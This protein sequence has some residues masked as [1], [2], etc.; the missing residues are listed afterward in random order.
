SEKALDLA[1]QALKRAQKELDL[2][3]MSPLDI[4]Q[5]QQVYATAEIGVSQA[6]FTLAQAQNALRKQLGADL[7]P[8]I[9]NLPVRL[10]E[11]V[12][13]PSDDKAIDAEAAVQTALVNRPDLKSA[14]QTL[15]VDEL[16]IRKVRND[17]LPDLSLTGTYTTQ[18][19]GALYDRTGFLAGTGGFGD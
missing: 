13:P 16:Q 5:P 2:G 9:R 1:D 15:D 7:D 11:T 6:K 14:S 12:L 10:T 3:A 19:I 17:F 4:Y 8:Q 18:G